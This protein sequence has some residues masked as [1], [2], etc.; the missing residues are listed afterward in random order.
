MPSVAVISDNM[1]S[2]LGFTTEEHFE[3]LKKGQSGVLAKN[4]FGRL[5]GAFS[6]SAIDNERLQKASETLKIVQG[7]TRLEQLLILSITDA[8]KRCHID[9][10]K[11]NTAFVLSSTKGNINLIQQP[12]P[13]AQIHLR[14]TGR[15]IQEYF[16]NPNTPVL[17]C[18]A[19]ISGVMAAIVGAR[20]IRMGKY[21]H[22]VV[23]GADILSEF[24]LSGFAALKAVSEAPCRPFDKDRTG[25]SLGEGCATLVLSAH[26]QSTSDIQILGGSI[27]NDA[28]HI[29]GPSRTGSG[30][31]Q[32]VRNALAASG[33]P[34]VDFISAH[35]T[36]TLYNDEMEAK[37]FNAVGLNEVPLNR[38]KGYWGHT[39]GAAGVLEIVA[40]CASMRNDTLIES[41]GYAA[42]GVSLPLNI[43]EA[44]ASAAIQTCLKTSS[45]FGGC[46]GAV[47]L[48]KND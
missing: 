22:V 5:T 21:E 29:S 33:N 4:N 14:Q 36:A 46:N 34:T 38:F 45:G 26:A 32:A 37:A 16:R 15:R 31:Q 43:I 19:C 2:S 24:I 18:N 3:K 6:I 30:L 44:P 7:Y 25:I 8:L 9:V 10:S 1:I 48:Q 42:S 40:S 23:A 35:G 41:A 39:L 12:N 17:V 27:S 28:N 13:S 47:V 20:L 11:A